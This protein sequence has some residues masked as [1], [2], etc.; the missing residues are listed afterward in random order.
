MTTVAFCEQ[1]VFCQ[2]VLKKHWPK[3]K[4]Y[5]DVKTLT[6]S[7]LD[8][9]G[10]AVD[11]ICGGFPCQDISTA[12]KGAGLAGERSGLWYEFHRIIGEVKPKYAFIEN[13][14]ALRSKGLDE[15]LRGLT[16]LGYDAEWHCIPASAIGAPHRRD[17]VWIIAYPNNT[18]EPTSAVN[19]ETRGLSIVIKNGGWSRWQGQ[20]DDVRMANGLP[21]GVDRLKALGNAVVPQIPEII[22]KAIMQHEYSLA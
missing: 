18:S 13:V 19:A 6:K 8:A 11:V 4:L 20:P 17:R 7:H 2:A 14:A 5:D 3:V 22:G 12:G 21:N 9:D 16:A 15:I 10:I 1:D